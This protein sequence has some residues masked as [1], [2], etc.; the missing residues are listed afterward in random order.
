MCYDSRARSFLASAHARLK[1]EQGTH[2]AQ[3]THSHTLNHQNGVPT[4]CS[5]S[6]SE[7]EDISPLGK[8]RGTPAPYSDSSLKNIHKG[9][10]FISRTT[11]LECYFCRC[12]FPVSRCHYHCLL[13]VD[14]TTAII[15]IAISTILTIC[16]LSFLQ[17]VQVPANL[18]TLSFLLHSELSF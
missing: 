15:N 2:D 17:A 11:R 3:E 18:L 5:T 10:Y 4:N 14:V 8:G 6:S 12:H 16:Y 9:L 7:K 13:V 1:G